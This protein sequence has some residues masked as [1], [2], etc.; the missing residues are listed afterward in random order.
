MEK[1]FFLAAFILCL[2]ATVSGMPLRSTSHEGPYYI[3]EVKNIA[4]VEGCLAQEDAESILAKLPDLKAFAAEYDR[5]RTE[6]KCGVFVGQA[7]IVGQI[8]VDTTDSEN[9]RWRIVHIQF[10]NPNMELTH[11]F[12]ITW[13]NDA[14]VTRREQ[15]L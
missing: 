10:Q 6:N 12:L 11:G 9:G 15:Q 7:L 13:G 1:K 8:G 5:L 4:G 3:G 14:I 2:A